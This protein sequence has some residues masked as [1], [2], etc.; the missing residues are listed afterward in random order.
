MK[1][2]KINQRMDFQYTLQNVSLVV[3]YLICFDHLKVTYLAKSRMYGFRVLLCFLN[4]AMFFFDL[5]GFQN[6]FF[7]R[8]LSDLSKWNLYIFEVLSSSAVICPKIRPTIGILILYMPVLKTWVFKFIKFLFWFL[9]EFLVIIR[10]SL[11]AAVLREFMLGSTYYS[12]YSSIDDIYIWKES[13]I[14][15]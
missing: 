12:N 15:Y 14:S 6:S 4:F 8:L 5:C 10:S 9:F 3:I 2:S 11:W 13:S 7:F 1:F